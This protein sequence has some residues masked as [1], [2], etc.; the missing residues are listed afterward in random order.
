[1]EGRGLPRNAKGK[2]RTKTIEGMCS[3]S[4]ARTHAR[5]LSEQ[6]WPN[7]PRAAQRQE[8]RTVLDVCEVYGA[9]IERHRPDLK[10]S[11]R[12]AYLNRLDRMA[13]CIGD[14][15]VTELRTAG[16]V[17]RSR[18]LKKHPQGGRT[19]LSDLTTLR[20][21]VEWL[22]GKGLTH[23]QLPGRVRIKT[24]PAYNHYTPSAAEVLAVLQEI[25]EKGTPASWWHRAAICLLWGT[26]ARPDDIAALTWAHIG[27][28]TL[29]IPQDTKTGSRT[30]PLTTRA[31][32]GIELCRQHNPGVAGAS[33]W[34]AKRDQF[35]G[36]VRRRVH[37]ACER[38]GLPPW[39]P[40]GLR[41]LA[42]DEMRRAGVPLEVA[43]AITGHSAATMMNHYRTVS[44]LEKEAAMEKARLGEVPQG[45]VVEMGGKKDG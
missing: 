23:L 43:G 36:P 12:A 5:T 38:L 32:E 8:I 19:V 1:V 44:G 9:Q 30:I 22:R 42:V 34:T 13:H 40:Y 39:S 16:D 35:R 37:L 20:Q 27:E 14:V 29:T 6:D 26:G 10:A 31:R 18:W 41:R 28:E 24:A 15:P 45:K 2:Q 7:A 4:E 11:T 3:E 25:E 17:H 33:L 21:A